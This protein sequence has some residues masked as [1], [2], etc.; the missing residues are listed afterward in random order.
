MDAGL[1]IKLSD[2]K[3]I[4]LQNYSSV[5]ALHCP[6]MD[7]S[8]VPTSSAS[9]AIGITWFFLS[10]HPFSLEQSMLT[11]KLWEIV[12]KAGRGSGHLLYF[13]S[14]MRNVSRSARK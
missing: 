14:V 12:T 6:P 8:P 3:S 9:I 1:H 5:Q 7:I 10:C 2:L 11:L 13:V 4:L